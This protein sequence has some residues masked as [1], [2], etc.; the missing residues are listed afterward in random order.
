LSKVSPKKITSRERERRAEQRIEQRAARQAMAE[1][2]SAE[3]EGL[4]TEKQ[5][6]L[7]LGL[8]PWLLQRLR[9]D[10]GGPRFVRLGKQ[11][12]RYRPSA[13]NEWAASREI[14]NLSQHLADNPEHA[15]SR[16][17]LLAVAAHARLSRHVKSESENNAVA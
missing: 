4:L 2:A 16:Q 3:V 11:I 5:A 10:G 6:A 17:R 14:D 7:A 1:A 13:L 15:A 8:K 9:V 12:F